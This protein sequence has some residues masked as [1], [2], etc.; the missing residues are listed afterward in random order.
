MQLWQQNAV[1][2]QQPPPLRRLPTTPHEIA[3]SVHG[4]VMRKAALSPGPLP[5]IAAVLRDDVDEVMIC[6]AS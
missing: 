4:K 2:L 3:Q 5:D 1:V 6:C